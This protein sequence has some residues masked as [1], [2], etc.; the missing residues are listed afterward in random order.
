MRQRLTPVTVNA[1]GVHAAGEPADRAGHQRAHRSYPCLTRL[2]VECLPSLHAWDLS[3]VEGIAILLCR[4]IAGLRWALL[5]EAVYGRS[6]GTFE[7]IT[8]EITPT[9][10]PA[11]TS[12][13]KWLAVAITQNQTHTGEGPERLREPPQ[14]TNM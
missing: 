7:T 12:S 9:A 11:A 14:D 10:M 1:F 2:S 5:R 4:T 6:R 8:S 3:A 13:Q